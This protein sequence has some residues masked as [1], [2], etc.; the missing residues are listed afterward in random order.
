LP[1]AIIHAFP[2]TG[3]AA[4]GALLGVGVVA[5]ASGVDYFFEHRPL[6][7]FLITAAHSIVSLTIM[8][9]IIGAWQ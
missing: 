8:G 7:L 2:K 6:K 1:A 5:M 4:I 9:T 3:G